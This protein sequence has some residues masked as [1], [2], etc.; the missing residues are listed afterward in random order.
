MSDALVSIVI[1]CYRGRRYLSEAIDSCLTQTHTNLEVIVVDDASPDLDF[2]VAE[3]FSRRDSR[4]R[5]IRRLTNGRIS[6][7]LNDGY[8]LARGD[9]FTRLAQDDLFR[10]DAV[11]LLLRQ[12]QRY[13]A[14][15]LAY[16]DM[17]L[18]DD[19]GQF[20]QL[21]PTEPPERALLPVDRVGLCVMWPRAVFVVVGGFDPAHD[22]CDDY[23]FFLRISRQFALTRVESEAPFYFRYHA[24]QGSIAQAKAHDIAMTQAQ[25]SHNSALLRRHPFRLLYWRRALLGN[26]RLLGRIALKRLT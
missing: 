3:E 18:I 4:V 7:A 11:A 22:L 8:A 6:R 15:G 5:V 20:L 2:E 23:E 19:R 26:L 13:P 12:L 1:P 17:Q 24:D 21:M 14:A 9:Y 10:N 16:A 25:L